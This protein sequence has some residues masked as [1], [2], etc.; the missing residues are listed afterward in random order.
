MKTF[1][2]PA[3]VIGTF[4]QAL[5]Q[6]VVVET[7]TVVQGSGAR[8]VFAALPPSYRNSVLLLYAND[9]TGEPQKW[10]L[11][12]ARNG[13]LGNV[14]SL[15]V[16]G[17]Q[18]VEEQRILGSQLPDDRTPIDPAKVIVDSPA[19]WDAAT[20]FA[21][22]KQKSLGTVSYALRQT[23][24]N[25]APTWTVW[26]FNASGVYIGALEILATTGDVVSNNNQ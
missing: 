10:S 18:V 23:G 6:S 13:S 9:A 12:A 15:S 16:V 1:L 5:G 7:V 4:L 21:Q 14:Y 2:I 8:A 17:G 3:I 19:V 22:S 24:L 11:I 26:C 25:A 20:A